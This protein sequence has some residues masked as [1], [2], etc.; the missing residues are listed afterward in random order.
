[1]TLTELY[2]FTARSLRGRVET[3]LFDSLRAT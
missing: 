3:R 2:M 1:M